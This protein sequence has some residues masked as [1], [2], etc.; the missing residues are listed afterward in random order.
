[1]VQSSISEMVGATDAPVTLAK[2]RATAHIAMHPPTGP[3][4]SA[5]AAGA[6]PRHVYLNLEN[7]TST[8]VPSSYS[9]YLNLP[10]GADP[11]QNRHLFA[12]ILP[13]FGIS[14]ASRVDDHYSGSGINRVLD[15]TKI[16]ESL[17][18]QG[19]WDPS[20]LQVTFV[21]RGDELSEVPVKVGR[22]SLYYK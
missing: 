17:E 21:P 5:L 15:V 22:A 11:Q 3:A 7:V 13:S 12:G 18:S 14:E 4:A 8:G 1:M 2:D 19:K 10:D 6:P 9:V 16:V 20:H